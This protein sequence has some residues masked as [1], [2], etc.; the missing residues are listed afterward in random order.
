MRVLNNKVKILG[1]TLLVTTLSSEALTLGRMRGAAWIGQPLEVTIP[2]QLNPGEDADGL[3]FEADVFHADVRQESS[4]VRVSVEATAQ[5]QSAQVSVRS[6]ALVDEPVVTIYLRTGCGQKTSRRYVLLADML[7]ETTP[8]APVARPALVRAVPAPALAPVRTELTP[9]ES[10][11][12]TK[13]RKVRVAKPLVTKTTEATTAPDVLASKKKPER[14]SG[15]S[16]LKLDPL[17]FLSDRVANLDAFMTF[18]PTADSLLSQQR[19]QTLEQAVK[20]GQLLAAKNEATLT[21]LK[22]RLQQAE[23]ERFPVGVLYGLMALV[24]AS[25]AAVAFLWTRQRRSSAS[26][27]EWWSGRVESPMHV[28]VAPVPAPVAPIEPD[29]ADASQALYTGL[30]PGKVAV[31][32]PEPE[33]SPDLGNLSPGEVDVD[34][35]EMSDSAFGDFMIAKP[36]VP[37]QQVPS[38][39]AVTSLPRALVCFSSDAVLD[40]RQQA[41]FFV[42]LG[43]SERAIRLLKRQIDESQTANPFYYLDL[44]DILQTHQQKNDFQ[45]WRERFQRVFTGRVPEFSL[46]HREG[47]GLTSYP[48][49]LS[50]LTALW[51]TPAVLAEIEASVFHAPGVSPEPLYD[52]AAFREL[53]LL[54]AV[55]K[56]G[57]ASPESDGL[58]PA[59]ASLGS[60]SLEVPEVEPFLSV[61]AAPVSAPQVLD[62]DLD[63]NLD[64]SGQMPL[65]TPPRHDAGLDFE[66]PGLTDFDAPSKEVKSAEDPGNLI[67]FKMTSVPPLA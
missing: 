13:V 39:N 36:G 47:R 51:H 31:A 6:S 21:D 67:D 24:L 40:L 43:E 46:F 17:D 5:S 65:A 49:L 60:A 11:P 55:A 28:D 62:L 16:R 33:L 4:R 45:H 27:E 38:S 19:M 12:A 48:E 50:R 20:E 64:F 57:I 59:L 8:P 42:S 32:P 54:H 63:L 35:L 58:A 56:S 41:E 9:L 15:Q 2:V 10:E 26:R 53:L 7:S 37:D 30:A 22:A 34:L 23:S 14:P 18:E 61:A 3:C 44:L 66:L 52:L 25:L 1:L 29:M